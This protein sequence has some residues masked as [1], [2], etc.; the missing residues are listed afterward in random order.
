MARRAPAAVVLLRPVEHGLAERHGDSGDSDE[1]RARGAQHMLRVDIVE[2]DERLDDVHE[3]C[4]QGQH[5]S[6]EGEAG[7]HTLG[8]RKSVLPRISFRAV[9]VV[10]LLIDAVGLPYPVQVTAGERPRPA[11]PFNDG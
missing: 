11:S 9:D 3:R 8:V 6:Y 5:G 2:V 4:T 10:D 7:R 1:W